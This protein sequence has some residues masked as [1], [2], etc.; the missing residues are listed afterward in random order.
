M[1][2]RVLLLVVLVLS[3]LTYGLFALARTEQTTIGVSTQS[4]KNNFSIVHFNAGGNDF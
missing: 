1:T 3:L 4:L 2:N